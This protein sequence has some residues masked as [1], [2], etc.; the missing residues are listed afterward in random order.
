MGPIACRTILHTYFIGLFNN[1]SADPKI[2]G[3][4][5]KEGRREAGETS[6]EQETESSVYVSGMMPGKGDWGYVHT[7]T[8]KCENASFFLV[9]STLLF[10]SPKKQKNQVTRAGTVY[11]ALHLVR[12]KKTK[13]L[14]SND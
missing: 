10:S 5:Y 11:L 3:Q 1:F 9:G 12:R 6:I 14:E 2:K 13:P 7:M 4:M 8:V